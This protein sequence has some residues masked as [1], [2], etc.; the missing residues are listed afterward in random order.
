M[1]Q[2]VTRYVCDLASVPSSDVLTNFYSYRDLD[3]A[4]RRINLELYLSA[5]LARK[6]RLVLVGEAPGYR[7]TRRTGVPFTSER[8]LADPVRCLQILG[9]TTPPEKDSSR[10]VARSEATSTVM[11]RTLD[12]LRTPVLLWAAVPF[13]PHRALQSAS[14]RRPSSH[15]I[16]L[17]L[18]FVHQ[19][20][21]KACP[22][23]VVALG[24]VAQIALQ[25][26]G[27]DA[28]RIRHP[29]RGGA[30]EFR[31]GLI[32]AIRTLPPK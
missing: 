18:R 23:R 16:E 32:E 7:G 25:H 6:P 17:G 27:I 2:W 30:T 19:L 5:A 31:R 20:L 22:A 28:V 10:E 29:A 15:E 21:R 4:R 26:A 13:H 24:A 9:C 14:N 3:S 8:Q 11:W 12:E 1:T